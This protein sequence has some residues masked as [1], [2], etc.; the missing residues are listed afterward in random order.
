MG[1]P[2]KEDEKGQGC[3]PNPDDVAE[4]GVAGWGGQ[5]GACIPSPSPSKVGKARD[6]G[7]RGRKRRLPA[8]NTI[9]HRGKKTRRWEQDASVDTIRTKEDLHW[10]GEKARRVRKKLRLITKSPGRNGA[11]SEQLKENGSTSLSA[12]KKGEVEGERDQIPRNP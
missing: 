8:L 4:E 1:S 9:N 6:W 10:E 11:R 3:E 5:G 7:K 12:Q 2:E